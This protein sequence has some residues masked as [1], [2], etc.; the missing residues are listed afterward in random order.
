[1]TCDK[2]CQIIT[3]YGIV[4]FLII[5]SIICNII[6][7]FELNDCDDTLGAQV[8][9]SQIVADITTSPAIISQTPIVYN[10]IFTRDPNIS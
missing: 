10:F 3:Q 8:N 4:T 5:A 9:P 1:M 2:N 6:Q 7:A